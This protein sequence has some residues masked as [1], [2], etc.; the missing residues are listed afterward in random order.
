M[1]L[2]W[3]LTPELSVFMKTLKENLESQLKPR[4]LLEWDATDDATET[5]EYDN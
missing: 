5:S 3:A 1:I 2:Q 4:E